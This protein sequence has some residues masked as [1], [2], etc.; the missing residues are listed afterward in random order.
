MV[1]TGLLSSFIYFV[2]WKILLVTEPPT[3]LICTEI[4]VGLMI[5]EIE[6]LLLRRYS[7]FVQIQLIF[8]T[9][10]CTH[11]LKNLLYSYDHMQQIF[12]ESRFQLTS[13]YL[14][15]VCIV[16]ELSLLDV[17]YTVTMSLLDSHNISG[18]FRWVS[19]VSG[20][21]SPPLSRT[22]AVSCHLYN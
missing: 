6:K 12:H 7:F 13:K 9:W 20:S 16:H 19:M 14:T 18:G 17:A 10:K 11:W 8:K 5:T 21:Q 4:V 22:P 2:L 15:D 1:I 3:L